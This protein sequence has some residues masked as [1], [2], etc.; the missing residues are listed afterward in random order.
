MVG[1]TIDR[2]RFVATLGTLG[3]ASCMCAAVSGMRVALADEPTPT[4]TPASKPG[5]HTPERA[6]KRLEFVDGWVQRFFE[7]VDRTLDPGARS[8]LME[9]NGVACF[10]AFAGPPAHP[11]APDAL[12]RFTAWVADAGAA[13]GYTMEG[14]AISFTFLGSAETGEASPAGVCLCPM[15]ESQSAATISPTYCL[16]S[17]GYVRE[18]HQRLLGRPVQ[19]ELV[20]SVLKGG[21]RCSFK[22]TVV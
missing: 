5:E 11:A 12:E 9:A 17:V 8:R 10:A 15:V 3:A 22:I 19:V 14:N 4:P 13:R 20:D 1:G 18:M 16:C 6:V 21:Q 7:A 2:K